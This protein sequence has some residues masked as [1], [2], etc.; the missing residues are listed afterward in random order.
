MSTLHSE[1]AAAHAAFAAEFGARPSCAAYAPGRVNLIGDHTDYTGG[2]A[3]PMTIDRGTHVLARPRRARRVHVSA[4]GYGCAFWSVHAPVAPD[5]PLWERYVLGVAREVGARADGGTA[6]VGVD[7]HVSGTLPVGTGLSSSASLTVAVALALAR[8]WEVELSETEAARLA[9]HV[10]HTDA[11]VQC[12]LM[13]QVAVRSGRAGHAVFLDCRSLE[14]EDVP[15]PAGTAVV[16]INSGV[17]RSL[18]GSAYNERR[19]SIEEATER[20]ARDGVTD[21]R[22][23]PVD[24]LRD[25]EP[26]QVEAHADALGEVHVRR[27]R[28]VVTENARVA[29]AAVALRTGDAEALGALMN[30]SHASLRDD[31]DVSGSELDLLVR[32][33][34]DAGALGARLT[35]AGFGG[36]TVNLVRDDGV[37][38]FAHTVTRGYACETGRTADVF[39]VRDNHEAHVVDLS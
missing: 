9:Q 1:R 12:G 34:Q 3:L 25:V 21:G 14:H 15:V 26:Q 29:A 10:E 20:L 23:R 39:V 27:A 30:A 33:A 7:V 17:G 2:L 35:G 5:R 28:H 11:G 16:V 18:A 22:G 36:C 24:S 4:E 32:L 38:G 31:Y 19:A 13:D 8:V 6:P 37:E